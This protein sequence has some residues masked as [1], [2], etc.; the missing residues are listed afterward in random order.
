M[1]ASQNPETL[2]LIIWTVHSFIRTETDARDSSPWMKTTE[3]F[4]NRGE[5]QAAYDEA[6][7]T[8]EKF[9]VDTM[10]IQHV[11]LR[12]HRLND[13]TPV[14]LLVAAAIGSPVNLDSPSWARS[15]K[16]WS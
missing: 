16:R 12:Q 15:T 2:M 8:A 11:T 4:V 3:A 7:T 14:A 13:E 10:L 9:R 1:T 5:A 6:L